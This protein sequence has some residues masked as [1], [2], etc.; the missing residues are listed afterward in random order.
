MSKP[1][2][3]CAARSALTTTHCNG[4]DV[5]AYHQSTA[6]NDRSAA[7]EGVANGL[8]GSGEW[9]AQE[10]LDQHDPFGSELRDAA[11]LR[12]VAALAYVRSLRDGLAEVM[13]L[14]HGRKEA[15]TIGCRTLPKRAV[16]K[17][18]GSDAT[19]VAPVTTARCPDS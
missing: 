4:T 2:G 15:V 3:R 9:V 19:C 17:P 8:A 13:R 12:R 5:M 6:A 14:E 16:G 1:T 10:I 7:D 18:R 11:F